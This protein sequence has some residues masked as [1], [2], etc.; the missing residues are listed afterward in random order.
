M[1]PLT[2]MVSPPS[3]IKLKVA[4]VVTPDTLAVTVN[5]PPVPL[6]IGAIVARPTEL[7][8]ELEPERDALARQ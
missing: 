7:V 1:P 5:G 4:G 2:A 8:M 6:A 3:L